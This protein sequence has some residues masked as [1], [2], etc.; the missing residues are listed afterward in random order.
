MK[1]TGLAKE[2]IAYM[3][4]DLN[5]VLYNE[6]GRI[7]R[8]S[9]GCSKLKSFKLQIFISE[10]NGG[11]GAVREFVEHILKKDGKWQTFLENN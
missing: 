1:K 7:V 6:T 5:D 8:S 2:E 10:K 11:S 4:D 9:K 3:G